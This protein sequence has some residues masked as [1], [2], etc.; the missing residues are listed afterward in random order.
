VALQQVLENVS[1]EV[2]DVREVINGWTTC[3]HFHDPALG[4]QGLKRL[5][6]SRCSI[7]KADRH[8]KLLG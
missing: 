8:T 1:A 7:K 6:R 2:S 4:V 3:V 5:N